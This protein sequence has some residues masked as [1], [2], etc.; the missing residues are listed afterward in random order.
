MRNEFAVSVGPHGRIH[1][2]RM[3][4]LMYGMDQ[5]QALNLIANIAILAEI[6]YMM[7]AAAMGEIKSDNKEGQ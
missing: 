5:D 6:P 1:I 3:S 4:A 7:I 2:L